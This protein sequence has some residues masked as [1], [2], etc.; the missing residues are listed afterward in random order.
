MTL[1]DCTSPAMET[2]RDY[3]LASY[4]AKFEEFETEKEIIEEILSRSSASALMAY[5]TDT[6]TYEEFCDF[7]T[8]LEQFCSIYG[9]DFD[10]YCYGIDAANEQR[11]AYR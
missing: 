4:V 10:E 6:C 9:F 7:T 2:L 3:K 5:Q 8:Q 11:G 1:K